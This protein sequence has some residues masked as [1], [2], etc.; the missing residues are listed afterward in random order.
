MGAK[1]RALI[2]IEDLD[3]DESSRKAIELVRQGVPPVYA[4]DAAGA[5][6]VTVLKEVNGIQ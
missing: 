6:L 5:D 1:D 3:L 4:S 2:P